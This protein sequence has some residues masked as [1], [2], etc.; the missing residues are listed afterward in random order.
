MLP[1]I[2]NHVKHVKHSSE[3]IHDI[4]IIK[5]FVNSYLPLKVFFYDL[6]PAFVL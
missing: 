1:N 4:E 3:P 5:A 6:I 2:K